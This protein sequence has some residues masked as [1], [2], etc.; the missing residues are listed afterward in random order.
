MR[1]RERDAMLAN[2]ETV[3]KRGGARRRQPRR[4]STQTKAAT[5]GRRARTMIP[6]RMWNRRSRNRVPINHP[7][8]ICPVLMI[9]GPALSWTLSS[10]H[11]IPTHCV[12]SAHSSLRRKGNGRTEFGAQIGRMLQQQHAA[13]GASEVWQDKKAQP[14]LI[15]AV[16]ST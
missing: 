8:A 9:R 16:V 11:F 6:R 5:T 3:G 12:G 10:A 13:V 14:I 15:E 4:R 2:R 7:L 1:V